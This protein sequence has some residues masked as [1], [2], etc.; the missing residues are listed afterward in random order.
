MDVAGKMNF[1]YLL[2]REHIYDTR[3][4]YKSI[5][6]LTTVMLTFEILQHDN[7]HFLY[8]DLPVKT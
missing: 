3:F 2:Q 4:H 5:M 7:V 8:L 6:A 1:K